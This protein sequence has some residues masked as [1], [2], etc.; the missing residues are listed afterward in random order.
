MKTGM[1]AGGNRGKVRYLRWI[2]VLVVA[3]WASATLA[4]DPIYTPLFSR[5][6]SGGYDVVAYFTEQKP[7]KGS[8]KFTTKYMGAK[9]HFAS[10]EHLDRFIAEP[11]AYAPQYGGYCAYGVAHGSTAKTDPFAWDLYNGKLYLNYN[12]AVGKRWR[13]DKDR[14]IA[15]GDANW[16]EVLE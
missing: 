9:W 2:C 6:A 11:D 1:H 14:L 4:K 15:Q 7:V 3:S 13:A 5:I 16:P 10:Q 12:K 8:A